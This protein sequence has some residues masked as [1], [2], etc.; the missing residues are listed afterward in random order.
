M[1]RNTSGNEAHSVEPFCCRKLVKRTMQLKRSAATACR[2]GYQREGM[3]A[4]EWF[5]ASAIWVRLTQEAY[6]MND[7]WEGTIL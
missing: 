7:G 1:S 3:S 6:C 2:G 5:H 4:F